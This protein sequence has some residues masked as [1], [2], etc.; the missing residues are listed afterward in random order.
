V[1]YVP[2][3]EPSYLKSGD[4]HWLCVSAPPR[5]PLFCSRCCLLAT[6]WLSCGP[7]GGPRRHNS[8]RHCL[9]RGKPLACVC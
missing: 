1:A 8:L 9:S 2:L 3:Y 7:A 5:L 6:C 4:T